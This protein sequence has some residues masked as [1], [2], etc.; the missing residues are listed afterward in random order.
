MSK[1]IM[2]FTYFYISTAFATIPTF[3]DSLTKVINKSI[4][5]QAEKYLKFS[6]YYDHNSS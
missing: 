1:E 6:N 3:R 5:K 4:D 2:N